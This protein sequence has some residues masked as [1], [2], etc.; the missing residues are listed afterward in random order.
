MTGPLLHLATPGEWRAHLAAGAIRPSIAEFVHLSTPEQVQ[1]PANRI[2]AGRS[3]L[4][5]L[6][7]DPDRIGVPVRWEP[8]LPTD[9]PSMRFPHAYGAVPTAA[10]LTVLPYRPGPDGRFAAPVVG[11]L[12]VAGRLAASGPSLL[13][14]TATAEVPVAGGVAVLTDPVPASYEHN[15]LV[16]DGSVGVDELVAEADRVLGGAGFAHRK[17]LLGGAHRATAAALA[18]RGWH[19]QHLVAMAA[20]PGGE[21]D[22][23]AE[24][25]DREALRPVWDAEARGE[26]FITDEEVAQLTDR[27]RLEEATVDLR[28]LGVR[29]G[30]ATV[31]AALLKIDGATAVLDM[32]F[33]DAAHRRHGYGD[34]LVTTASAVA[35]AAGCDL[36][37]LDAA[38]GDWPRGWYARRGFAEVGEW[39]SARLTP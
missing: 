1:L 26:P 28:Y 12:D 2:F 3:D 15:Q 35:G 34:A 18:G 17:I 22:R 14:R 9:P 37:G 11:P 8:G 10:V 33:T 38:A 4:Q 6:V 21:A 31:A 5:L 16:I 20:T 7:L 19:V 25:L 29:S 13:R 30:G 27:Y 32:V 24:L 23:R 39:W 36:L